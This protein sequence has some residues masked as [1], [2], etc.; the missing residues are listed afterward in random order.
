[1]LTGALRREEGEDG[2]RPFDP[3][4][5]MKAVANLIALAFGD[6]LDP[7][8]RAVLEEMRRVAR[9]GPLLWWLYWPGSTRGVPHGFVW[10][11][12]G[13]VVGNVSLRRAPGWGGYLVG[14]VAVHPERRGRGIGRGLVEKALERIAACGGRW[15][16]L[17]VRTD[18]EV[19]R[20]LYERLG[21]RDVGR[22]LHMLR[23]ADAP[24]TGEPPERSS[25][26]RARHGEGVALFGIAR[27]L[28]PEPQRPIVGTSRAA[29][30]LGWERTLDMWLAGRRE[31]WWVIEREGGAIE[32]GVRAVR[33]RRRRP[34][35]LEVLV[36][37][38]SSGRF[39][40]LLVWRGMASLCHS[41]AGKAVETIIPAP[42][43]GLVRAFEEAGFR[44]LRTLLQM[45]LDLA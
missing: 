10:I 27:R 19:A 17:E 16:G 43:E 32:G 28:V 7:G 4:R 41:E 30:R 34:D 14:N 6:A 44:R 3:A 12:S 5:D 8:G 31:A 22:T 26:R 36:D 13:R 9:W 1:M 20:G 11:E 33:E 23:R 25:L 38:A 37:P 18:N 40:P 21:F 24:W 29:Y 42:E 45:R 35:S 2:V 39:E 15:V